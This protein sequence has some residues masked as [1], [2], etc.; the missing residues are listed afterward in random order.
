MIGVEGPGWV[1]PDFEARWESS[2]GRE[3]ILASA[4]MCEEDPELQVL[5]AHLLA[6][7]RRGPR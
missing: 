1:A 4:R 7:C 3:M 5:S 6:F 2:E